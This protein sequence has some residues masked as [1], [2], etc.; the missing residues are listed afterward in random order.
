M[1]T[2]ALLISLIA[3]G[4]PAR[5]AD[6]D[7]ERNIRAALEKLSPGLQVTDVSASPVPGIY[8]VTVGTQIVYMT[9]DGKYL[10]QGS[11]FDTESRTDVTAQAMA[12]LRKVALERMDESESIVFAPR[13]DKIRHNVTVFTDID[14]GYCRRM[15]SQIDDYNEYGIA[16]HYLFFPR[17]GTGSHSYDKAVS[18]WCAEDQQSA[19]TAAKNG[20][21]P[22]PLT[23]DNPVRAQFQLGQQVGVQGTPAIV[24]ED[25]DMLPGYLPPQVLVQRLDEMAGADSAEPLDSAAR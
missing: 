15:H 5:A 8:E 18:V 13:Q 14:C 25:G 3:L 12:R 1:R 16:V 19:L 11:I 10:V 4:L 9:P 2:A 20:E 23:C 7:A 6:E 17:A 24:T 21:E 22:E